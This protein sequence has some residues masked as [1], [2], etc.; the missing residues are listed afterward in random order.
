MDRPT[1]TELAERCAQGERAAFEALVER[2]VGA[3]L[4]FATLSCGTAQAAEQAVRDALLAAWQDAPSLAGCSPRVWLLKRVR[5]ACRERRPA[6][7]RFDSGEF[8]IALPPEPEPERA[9]APGGL[10]CGEVLARVS[11]FIDG[12]L[13]PL[14]KAQVEAHLRACERCAKLGSSMRLLV[15]SLRRLGESVED[16]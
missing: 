7:A 6:S 13:A 14:E 12:E 4:R 1:D 16:R 10:S 2:H 3:L 8:L 5:L 15:E 11:D 9:R